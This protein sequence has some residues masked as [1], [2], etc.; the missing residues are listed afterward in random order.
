MFVGGGN[1]VALGCTGAYLHLNCST[2]QFIVVTDQFFEISRTVPCDV[3]ESALC[4]HRITE[5]TV[6][7]CTGLQVRSVFFVTLFPKVQNFA[8]G[9]LQ[10][11]KKLA[12][13]DFQKQCLHKC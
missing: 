3:S 4:T 9:N 7:Y 10:I 12:E 13:V 1:K 5:P 6:H 11:A 8:H 2:D